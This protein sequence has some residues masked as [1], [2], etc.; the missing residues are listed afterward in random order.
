[1]L[2][3]GRRKDFRKF[4]NQRRCQRTA[5]DNQRQPPPQIG[6][7]VGKHNIR[8][9]ERYRNRRQRRQPDKARQ[10]LFKVKDFLLAVARF[11]NFSVQPVRKQRGQNHQ[12]AHGENPYN[13]TRLKIN[14]VRQH[15]QIAVIGIHHARTQN[16]KADKRHAGNAVGF[17]TVR[18]RADGVARV[19][20]GAIGN[21]A[22]IARI[23]LA[24]FKDNFHQIRTDIGNFGENAAANAQ[25]RR[26]ERF[27]DGKADKARAR[28]LFRYEQQNCHHHN[29]LNADEQHADGHAGLERQAHYLVRLAFKR[30]KS[31][32]RIRVVVDAHTEPRH[33]IRAE[34]TQH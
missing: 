33:R 7:D 16:D 19:V 10:R 32:A 22:R 28:T 8:N 24:D 27:A 15:D 21:H 2:R 29:Q 18:S 26:A 4:R 34:N 23:V 30:R 11:G 6:A 1:M 5:A 17:K 13:Q 25:R 3:F 14:A 20:A 9:A 12:N 31:R